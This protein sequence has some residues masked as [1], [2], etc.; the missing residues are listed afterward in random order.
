[1]TGPNHLWSGDWE[2][3][4]A[5]AGESLGELAPFPEPSDAPLPAPLA[6]QRARAGP[7]RRPRQRRFGL[8]WLAV[9]CGLLVLVGVGFALGGVFSSSTT[10]QQVTQRQT[11]RPVYWLGMEISNDPYGR[12][13]IQTVALGSE[14][15]AARL[16]P[17]DII[18]SVNNRQIGSVSQL[19]SA[20]AHLPKGDQVEVQVGRG[21][22]MYTTAV[23]LAAP[24]SN[25]P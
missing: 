21:S 20:V 17:G 5:E 12:V 6:P 7:R 15:D 2:R 10:P 11:A 9:A 3:E 13:V 16:D 22:A 19:R 4:S 23:T 24:P 18:S 1:M 14:A 8:G 25:E